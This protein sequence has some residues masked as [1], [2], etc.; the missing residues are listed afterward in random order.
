MS[1]E[2]TTFHE[3]QL[4]RMKTTAQPCGATSTQLLTE[5]TIQTAAKFVEV[6]GMSKTE[7]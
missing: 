5:R 7:R 4:Q 3:L 1:T 6:E 2:I